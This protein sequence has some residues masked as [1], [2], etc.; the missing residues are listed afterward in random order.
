MSKLAMLISL[1]KVAKTHWKTTLA[2]LAVVV[3]PVLFV[4][5]VEGKKRYAVQQA[6]TA[7]RLKQQEILHAIEMQH[8]KNLTALQTNFLQAIDEAHRQGGRNVTEV[9]TYYR[10]NP[11]AN[12]MCLT[13][14]RVRVAEEGRRAVHSAATVGADSVQVPAPSHATDGADTGRMDTGAS[15]S[16]GS[17]VRGKAN[18]PVKLLAKE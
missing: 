4:I 7:E 8:Q 9:R 18:S 17:R 10:E 12:I 16:S 11:D 3:L 1:L 14:D 13:D 15:S 2:L 6:L 5:Y